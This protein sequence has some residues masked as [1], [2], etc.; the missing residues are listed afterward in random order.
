MFTNGKWFVLA[1]CSLLLW[2]LWG[3]FQKLATNHMGPRHVFVFAAL[4]T[5]LI[6]FLTF[7]SL[8]FHIDTNM[9]GITFAV[10]AGLAGSLGGLF[11][12]SSVSRGKASVV[13]TMTALYPVV[14]ILL[15]F[16][17]LR[18]E[19]TIRQG[20]GIILALISMVLLAE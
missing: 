18:E 15:S 13:I 19:I 7:A 16:A 4:G 1:L 3:F 10:L 5:V 9:K 2:G 12:V 8:R 6:V 11:F 14:T 20:I 17:V